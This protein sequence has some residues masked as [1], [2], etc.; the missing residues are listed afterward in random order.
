MFQSVRAKRRERAAAEVHLAPMIDMVFILLIFFL[1]T[2]TF[3]RETGVDVRRPRAATATALDDRSLRVGIDAEGRAF[4]DQRRIDLFALRA[5]VE[6]R[7]QATPDLSIVLVAD[8]ST[9]T[10]ALIA[11]MDECRTAGAER[12]AVASRRE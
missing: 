7:V 9:D 5:L 3:T 12:I 6:R 1:V 11:V 4:V 2:T 8:E 10:G